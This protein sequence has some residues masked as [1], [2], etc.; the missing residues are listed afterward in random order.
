MDTNNEWI[1]HDG[2][3]CPIPWAKAGEWEGNQ[4]DGMP[5]CLGAAPAAGYSW[6]VIKCYR[7]TDGRI[8]VINGIN[9]I[10][11]ANAFE[12]EYWD[13]SGAGP[14]IGR[15]PSLAFALKGKQTKE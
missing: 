10:P 5:G 13:K 8:P 6:R 14:Q 3:P 2:G 11:W 4:D 1:N 15:V 7:L 9:P 12:Y